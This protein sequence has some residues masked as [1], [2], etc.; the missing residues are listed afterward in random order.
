MGACPRCGAKVWPIV[1]RQRI[2]PALPKFATARWACRKCEWQSDNPD[3]DSDASRWPSVPDPD[4]LPE[5]ALC[6][7][8]W[9]VKNVVVGEDRSVAVETVC[10]Y[11]GA[12]SLNVSSAPRHQVGTPGSRC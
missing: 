2:S 5:G 9:V 4:D 12:L 1:I 3:D 8:D 6:G 11:C 10:R 7:H